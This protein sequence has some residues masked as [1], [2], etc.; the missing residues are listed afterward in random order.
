MLVEAI[1]Q[2]L[3]YDFLEENDTYEKLLAV[4]WNGFYQLSV[5]AEKNVEQDYFYEG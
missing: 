3:V 2:E 5:Y 1:D 4:F